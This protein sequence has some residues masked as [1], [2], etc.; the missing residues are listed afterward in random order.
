MPRGYP[1]TV[2]VKE[3]RKNAKRTKARAR[4]PDQIG[5]GKP[6][7]GR[8]KG[9]PNKINRDLKEAYL[10]AANLAG[11]AEGLVGYLKAQALQ[12][13]PSPF[14]TGLSKL[15][16]LLLEGNKGA[17]LRHEIIVRFE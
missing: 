12:T 10:L 3:T 8:P 5:G 1:G 17:P 4:R 6:G 15:L 13:N 14:M 9:V 2:S 7:P 16:P 11:G